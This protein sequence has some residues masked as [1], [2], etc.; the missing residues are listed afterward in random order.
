M[1][2]VRQGGGVRSCGFVYDVLLR[3][4]EYILAVHSYPNLEVR[5]R[6]RYICV[7]RRGS[8]R[9]G[10]ALRRLC[11]TWEMPAEQLQHGHA[12]LRTSQARSGGL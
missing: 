5:W 2:V 1:L 11:G 6:N 10:P 4:H 12:P 8:P 3:T 9:A 7:V